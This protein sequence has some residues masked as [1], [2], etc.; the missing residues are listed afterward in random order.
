MI[1][2]PIFFLIAENLI[3][4]DKLN[5]VIFFFT[6]NVLSVWLGWFWLT[7]PKVFWNEFPFF[8][9]LRVYMKRFLVWLNIYMYVDGG[10][11]VVCV[12]VLYLRKIFETF[13]YPYMYICRYIFML[14]VYV[15][16]Q[17]H[18][19]I[20]KNFPNHTLLCYIYSLTW[21]RLYFILP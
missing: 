12:C 3:F 15:C 14:C 17:I 13:S 7:G 10:I 16:I 8:S 5:Y 20:A 18:N 21:E 9:M 1:N 11:K 19:S 2:P 4:I 6:E